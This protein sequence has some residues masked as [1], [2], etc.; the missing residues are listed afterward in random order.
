MPCLDEAET[1]A[2]CIRQ[3]RRF[4]DE[5]DV[6][7]EILIADNGSSDG[8]Q[9]IAEAE[10]A[11]VVRIAER[12]YGAALIGGIAAA[13]GTYVAMADADDSYDFGTLGPFLERLRAGDELVMGNR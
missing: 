9:E 8:S 7:G 5:H 6:D 13:R 11:R 1:L 2:T 3:A 4:L 10:G 12:G